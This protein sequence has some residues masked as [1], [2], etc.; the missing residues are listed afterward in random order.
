MSPLDGG[1]RSTYKAIIYYQGA[2]LEGYFIPNIS[3]GRCFI[4][5][6]LSRSGSRKVHENNA[7]VSDFSS[8]ENPRLVTLRAS[9]L[10]TSILSR[11]SD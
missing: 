4:A 7:P 6:L 5:Y 8:E 1:D 3:E 2:D 10:E 9:H 11:S